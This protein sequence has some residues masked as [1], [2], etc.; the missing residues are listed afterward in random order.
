VGRTGDRRRHL[1]R[2]R[3]SPRAGLILVVVPYIIMSAVSS[4]TL[5]RL[6]LPAGAVAWLGLAMAEEESEL[7]VAIHPTGGRRWDVATALGGLVIVV[8]A[9]TVMERSAET[10]GSHLDLSNL[11]VGGLVLAAVT[12]L[13]NAVGAVYLAS[14]GRGAA[15]LSEAMN[16][17][18]L[19]VLVGLFLPGIIV[20][21]GGVTGQGTLVAT[22]YACLTAISLLLAFAGRGLDRRAGLAIVSGYVV[23][24][25]VAVKA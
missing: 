1:R 2:I 6:G 20:G 3:C 21:L 22:W 10:L 7:A 15:V 16:S 13:P 23:F 5:A 24:V 25:L 11:V 4:A 12:S 8:A 14:R 19:N 17:N 18:M 9:S